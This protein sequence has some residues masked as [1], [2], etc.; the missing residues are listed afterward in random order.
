MIKPHS[1]DADI[2][3]AAKTALGIINE[4]LNGLPKAETFDYGGHIIKIGEYGVCSY[5]TTPI[6]EA[7]AAEEALSK[8]ADAEQD[9]TVREHLDIAVELLQA[10]VVAATVRAELHN[11]EGTEGI[12]NR[13]LAFEYDRHIGEDYHHSHHGGQE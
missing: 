6:A 11:G 5:C 7:Q 2:R 8:R 12:L 3:E 10:E 9:E 4:V 13:L 1:E